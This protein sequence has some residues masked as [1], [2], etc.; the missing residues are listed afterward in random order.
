MRK[1]VA[2][3]LQLFVGKP[4]APVISVLPPPAPKADFESA[5]V[6]PLCQKKL[7]LEHPFFAVCTASLAEDV[8][9]P[10]SSYVA[11][12]QQVEGPVVY[13]C[14]RDTCRYHPAIVA[15][16]ILDEPERAYR[17]LIGIRDGQNKRE[18]QHITLPVDESLE[19]TAKG[20]VA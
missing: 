2:S 18:T 12:L 6:C 17:P 16:G 14:D 8:R 3:L 15:I 20:A 11:L 13:V 4:S 19:E 7:L 1:I 9:I 10:S 5:M